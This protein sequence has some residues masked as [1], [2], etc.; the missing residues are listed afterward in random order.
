MSD[1]QIGVVTIGNVVNLDLD[2][3]GVGSDDLVEPYYVCQEL[4]LT[5]CPQCRRTLAF[6]G[7]HAVLP[8]PPDLDVKGTSGAKLL[9]GVRGSESLGQSGDVRF[10]PGWAGIG[11]SAIEA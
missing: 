11:G 3:R 6:P 10:E 9:I 7:N 2:G 4:S 1:S 5:G 8:A